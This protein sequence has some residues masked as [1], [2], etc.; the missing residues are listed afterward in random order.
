MDSHYKNFKV[1]VKSD[2]S[3]LSI[4]FYDHKKYMDFIKFEGHRGYLQV[5]LGDETWNL[6]SLFYGKCFLANY[7][8]NVQKNGAIVYDLISDKVTYDRVEGYDRLQNIAVKN[9]KKIE[10][11]TAS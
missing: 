5:D 8:K 7:R 4:T 1:S 2:H 3:N 11:V 9:M 10:L 6:E